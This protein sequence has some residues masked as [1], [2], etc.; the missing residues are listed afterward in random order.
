MFFEG[1]LHGYK[2]SYIAVAS[3]SSF[4]QLVFSLST[5]F[6]C[7]NAVHAKKPSVLNL[8]C[9]LTTMMI[10]WPLL[11]MTSMSLSVF[12]ITSS[13][14]LSHFIFCSLSDKDIDNFRQSD[15]ED[16]NGHIKDSVLTK[17]AHKHVAPVRKNRAPTPVVESE[18]DDY[19]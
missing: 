7:L 14:Q 11:P 5:F 2:V 18:D 1:K 19:M 6:Q 13:P 9:F 17:L 10:L 8:L 15:E 16:G 4:R 12:C 3:A